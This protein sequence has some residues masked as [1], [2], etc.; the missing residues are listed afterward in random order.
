MQIPADIAVTLQEAF[1]FGIA[2][3]KP[4]ELPNTDIALDDDSSYEHL[5]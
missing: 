5:F 4:I 2:I 3:I 1:G